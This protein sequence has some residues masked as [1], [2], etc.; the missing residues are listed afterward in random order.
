MEDS[1]IIKLYWMRDEDAIVQTDQK[2]G[3]LCRGL[4]YRILANREDSEECVS[5]TYLAAWHQMP[6]QK[7]AYLKGFL[8][9]IVRNISISRIRERYSKKNGGGELSLVL[10]ELENTLVSD[11]NVE[12]AYEQ[13]ELAA[14]INRFLKTI[15]KDDRVIF[16]CRY[17]RFFSV[18][19]IALSQHF[20]ESK[21]K[22]SLHRTRKKLH[23][24][25]ESEG[26]L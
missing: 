13:K 23:N 25:L 7:P 14:F 22:T 19:E 15:S 8:A 20:S 12:Q 11:A 4:S 18:S 3:K 2:Y 21:V 6:P 16:L 17:W 1:Q 10:E 26:L 9:R 24:F 5:D